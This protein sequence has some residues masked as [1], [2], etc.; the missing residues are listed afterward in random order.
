[1]RDEDEDEGT[2]KLFRF[3]GCQAV[4]VLLI[5]NPSSSSL[6]PHPR[7]SVAPRRDLKLSLLCHAQLHFVFLTG[8]HFAERVSVIVNVAHV[9]TRQLTMRLQLSS[10]PWLRASRRAHH[11]AGVLRSSRR[12][13]E[14]CRDKLEA[15]RTSVDSVLASV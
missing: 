7:P 14:S 6:I 10:Q 9:A 5:L 12:S 11:R 1:M 3:S 8:L 13:W 15:A 2:A 4:R